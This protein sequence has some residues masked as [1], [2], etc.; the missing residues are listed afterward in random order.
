[1]PVLSVSN[2][3]VTELF[4]AS[5]RFGRP[6]TIKGAGWI[7]TADKGNAIIQEQT[8]SDGNVVIVVRWTNYMEVDGLNGRI[9][10]GLPILRQSNSVYFKTSSTTTRGDRRKAP[11][12]FKFETEEDAREFEMWWL[13]KNGSIDSWKE[14]DAKKKAG[15]N[16]VNIKNNNLPLQERTNTASIPVHKRKA[17]PITGGPIRKIKKVKDA[18]RSLNLVCAIGGG[19]SKDDDENVP[20]LSDGRNDDADD[21]DDGVSDHCVVSA[22]K[23]VGLMPTEANVNGKLRAI[24]KIKRSNLKSI[25]EDNDNVNDD[26]KTVD[27]NENNS[28]DSNDDN[29]SNDS[30]GGEDVIIDEEDAP[31][32]QNWMTAFASYE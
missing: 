9:L 29:S 26:D 13:L 6:S 25:A 31:Q 21:D 3:T 2:A 19:D 7:A 22:F 16:I 10:S 32:S 20:A 4:K 23:T 24:V 14:E 17:D 11:F 18:G 28:K 30:A 1:M 8:Y 12:V 15:S 5:A 27:S